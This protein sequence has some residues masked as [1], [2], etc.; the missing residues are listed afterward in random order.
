[1][2]R[3]ELSQSLEMAQARSYKPTLTRLTSHQK[4]SAGFVP[5]VDRPGTLSG[6]PYPQIDADFVDP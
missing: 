4:Q 2:E 6:R 3:V 5:E 1:M